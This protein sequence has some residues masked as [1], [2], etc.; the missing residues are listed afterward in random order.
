METLDHATLKRTVREYWCWRSAT[1]D[2]RAAQQP[3]W[4]D[5]FQLAVGRD[6]TCR[7]LDVGTGTGFLA[8]GLAKAGHRVTGIDLSAGMVA[9]ARLNAAR[10]DLGIDLLVADAERPPFRQESFDV[11]VSRNL[12]WTLCEPENAL[13]RWHALLRPGG[14]VVLSDGVWN[15][16][17]LR[18]LL[19]RLRH[20]AHQF[21]S[22]QREASVPLQFWTFYRPI[23]KDLPHFRGVRANEVE[24]F[25]ENCGFREQVRYEHLFSGNPYSGK[26][27]KA[28]FVVAAVK[29]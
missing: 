2:V 11:I 7:I 12:L 22:G 29:G 6:R 9:R 25:L 13:R 21:L 3:E 20:S 5:I 17:G 23:N 1:F 16:A 19:R 4:W 24:A 8:L 27:K 15:H 18:G 28:F 14:R 10:N 26:R